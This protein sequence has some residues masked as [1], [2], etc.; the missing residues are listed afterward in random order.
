MKKATLLILLLLLLCGLAVWAGYFKPVEAPVPADNTPVVTVP[1]TCGFS[2]TSPAPNQ[3]VSFPLVVKGVVDNTDAENKGCS[4]QMFEG[5]AGSAQLYAYNIDG[6]ETGWQ[7]IGAAVP[8]T[9]AD[10]MTTSTTFAINIGNDQMGLAQGTQM[11]IV[12]EEEDA[13]GFGNPDTYE[14][15]LVFDSAAVASNAYTWKTYINEAYD[16]EL[17]YPS[18]TSITFGPAPTKK[19]EIDTGSGAVTVTAITKNDLEFNNKSGHYA[20]AVDANE[21]VNK[22]NGQPE[23]LCRFEEELGKGTFGYKYD[24]NMMPNEYPRRYFVVTDRDYAF[25]V[26]AVCGKE[27]CGREELDTQNT[28]L[29]S[30]ALTGGVTSIGCNK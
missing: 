30:F 17:L 6:K 26:S 10:W 27:G 19:F 21:W 22:E 20:Y 29:K 8:T 15:P 9:V 14:L 5:Q 16:F 23:T 7:K 11:K 2:V 4:W 13:A 24:A 18:N 28:M 1:P 3:K 12:F 25:D